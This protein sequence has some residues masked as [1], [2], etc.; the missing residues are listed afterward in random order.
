[1]ATRFP[2][3]IRRAFDNPTPADNLK[4]FDKPMTDDLLT[5]RLGQPDDLWKLD[6]LRQ[7]YH[8]WQPEW[9][10]M[11]TRLVEELVVEEIND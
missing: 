2:F 9:L 8:L 11:A 10:S 1:M 3:T 6:D 5:A 7:P 4:T